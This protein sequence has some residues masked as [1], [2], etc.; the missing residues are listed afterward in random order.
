MATVKK[1]KQFNNQQIKMCKKKMLTKI[2]ENEQRN[3]VEQPLP[4]RFSVFAQFSD[5]SLTRH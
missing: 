3:K 5:K 1:H 2:E 4:L